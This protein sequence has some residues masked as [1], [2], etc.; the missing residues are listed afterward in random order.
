MERMR[1]TTVGKKQGQTEGQILSRLRNNPGQSPSEMAGA[2]T[3]KGWIAYTGQ[4]LSEA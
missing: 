3:S 1:N 2:K 4:V